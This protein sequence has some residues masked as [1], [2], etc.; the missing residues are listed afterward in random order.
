MRIHVPVLG[1][2]ELYLGG[3]GSNMND[4]LRFIPICGAGT[5]VEMALIWSSWSIFEIRLHRVR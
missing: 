2:K 5:N 3:N 4:M 1:V